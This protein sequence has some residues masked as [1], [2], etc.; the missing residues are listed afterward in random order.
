MYIYIYIYIYLKANFKYLLIYKIS[1]DHLEL[2][3]RAIRAHGGSSN[4][5]NLKQF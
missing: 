1:Q 4:N 2:L 3:F 5:P